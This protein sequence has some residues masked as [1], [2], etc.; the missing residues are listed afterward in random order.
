MAKE[1]SQPREFSPCSVLF[2]SLGES[3]LI[4]CR[5]ELTG[6]R[7]VPNVFIGGKHIGGNDKTQD[8]HRKGDLVPL[9]KAVGAL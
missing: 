9:L 5:L 3:N 4:Y 6:Q 2:I 7:T 8:L 1:S